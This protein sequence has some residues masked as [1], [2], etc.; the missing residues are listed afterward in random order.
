LK[1]YQNVCV[2]CGSS[3]KIAAPY[4]QAAEALGHALAA[5]GLSLIYGGG[6]TGL[7]GILA[8]AA[9]EGGAEVI[10][11]IPENFNNPVLAHQHLTQMHVV[12]SMHE[13]KA[14]MIDLAQ[15]FITLP[16][17]YGTLEE[18]FE[19]LTW[20]QIGL[21]SCPIGILNVNG[22]FDPL[23]ALV[24]QTRMQGFIYE[25]HRAL[26]IEGLDPEELLDR[27]AGYVP[28]TNL[29]RWVKREGQS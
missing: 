9:L 15:A 16:G 25:E 1:P 13:R 20:A 14:M 4:H 11:V 19:V 28:P 17:G 22:Y 12:K 29:E 24:E 18:L 5:R 2:F 7:M 27:M 10:G 6:G 26:L 8:D 23:F 21:H 3:D